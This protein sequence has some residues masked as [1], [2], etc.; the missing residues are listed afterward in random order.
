M[1]NIKIIFIALIAIQVTFWNGLNF[2]FLPFSWHGTKNISPNLD[3]LNKPEDKMTAD[4]F[5]FGDKQF[6]FRIKS[7]MIQNAG[8]SFGRFTALKK[9]NYQFLYE[10]LTLLDHLD[11]RSNFTPSIASYIFGQTQ[12]SEDVRYIVDYL[13]THAEKDLE[14]KWWW[15]YQAVYLANKRLGDSKKAL[16]LAYKLSSTKADIPMWARQ[17]P[18]FILEGRGELVEAKYFMES[19]ANNIDDI[20][21]KEINF[22]N[23]FINERLGILENNLEA[24]SQNQP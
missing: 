23:Y 9:Y 6:Y 19:I 18:A 22:M 2:S 17:M 13:E 15:M 4:I 5:S 8:D 11:S 10:W 21:D 20:S 3:I 12:T 1:N 14:T 7:L 16:D 24:Q